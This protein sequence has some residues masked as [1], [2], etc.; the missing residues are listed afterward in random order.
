M[1]VRWRALGVPQAIVV[2]APGVPLDRSW[3]RVK[4]LLRVTW[5]SKTIQW[6]PV[7]VHGRKLGGYITASPG[8]LIKMHSDS[9]HLG[10]E[11]SHYF[12]KA[13]QMIFWY[14]WF[15]IFTVEQ[16]GGAVTYSSTLPV[17]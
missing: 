16:L 5:G 14:S 9:L 15:E 13:T 12:S 17:V 1:I 11:R 2:P 10:G 8:V 4:R 7:T 6:F 3:T